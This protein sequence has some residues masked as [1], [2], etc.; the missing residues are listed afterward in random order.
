MKQKS[1]RRPKAVLSVRTMAW[2]WV[3]GGLGVLGGCGGGASS[4]SGGGSGTAASQAPASGTSTSNLMVNTSSSAAIE[5]PA[6]SADG[7]TAPAPAP[8]LAPAPAPAPAPASVVPPPPPL[9]TPAVQAMSPG[10]GAAPYPLGFAGFATE[11]IQPIDEQPAASDGTG[12]FRL[13]CEASHFANDDPI[14][15]PGQPGRS[16]LH[17]FFGNTGTNAATTAESLATSGNS[18]CNGGIVNRTAYWAPAMIDMRTN[19][20]IL[21]SVSDFYYKTGYNGVQPADV[22]PFPKGLRMI[23]G[24]PANRTANEYGSAYR[25]MC[26]N[27][28][29]IRG[30][31]FVSCPVGDEMDME[32]FFPQCWDGINL[33][34]PDHKSHM[35]YPRGNGCPASHPVAL[36][37]VSIHLHYLIS[38]PNQQANWRLSSDTYSGPAGYSAHADWFN[39]WN[40]T[41]METWVR[42]C[43]NTARDCHSHLLGANRALY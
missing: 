42:E 26:H 5:T 27:N 13:R 20:P 16:H 30:Q 18:T 36:P 32:V 25:F 4:A 15:Y 11:R 9:T 43:E 19:R 7:G 24:D 34:S 17:I 29:N 38:E 40:Q 39:G 3:V 31:V 21:P 23:A 22:K 8:A 35:A 28:S 14:V 2:M 6:P 33:D 41:H 1:Q 12:S 37:E 10:Y